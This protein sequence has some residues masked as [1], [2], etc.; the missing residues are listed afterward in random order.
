MKIEIEDLKKV[1]VDNIELILAQTHR[2][3]DEV[4]SIGND[5]VNDFDTR[6]EGVIDHE[7]LCEA[8]K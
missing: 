4:K 8:G 6:R 3:F 5:H 1:K 7:T 2:D